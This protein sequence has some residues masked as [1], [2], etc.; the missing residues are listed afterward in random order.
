LE[1]VASAEG[2]LKVLGNG[3]NV[4]LVSVHGVGP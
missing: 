3:V 1:Q 2:T 4:K